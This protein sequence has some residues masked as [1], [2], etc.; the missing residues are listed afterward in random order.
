MDVVTAAIGLDSHNGGENLMGAIS[1]GD[2]CFPRDNVDLIAL[3]GRLGAPADPPRATHK[4][5]RAQIHAVADLVCQ[6]LGARATGIL[7]LT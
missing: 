6:Y 5:N 2:P 3:Q 7:G 4:F 1:Y